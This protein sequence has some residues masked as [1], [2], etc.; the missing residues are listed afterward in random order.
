MKNKINPLIVYYNK[1]I[2]RSLNLEEPSADW[3]WDQLDNTVVQLLSSGK[4]VYFPMTPMS[5]E[6]LTVNR[7]G[8][9]IVDAGATVFSGY[10]DSEEAVQAAEWLRTYQTPWDDYGSKDGYYPMLKIMKNRGSKRLL[11][12]YKLRENYYSKQWMIFKKKLLK[13]WQLLM[14]PLFEHDLISTINRTKAANFMINLHHRI[15][16]PAAYKYLMLKSVFLY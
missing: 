4:K 6:W 14:S 8:G 13:Q 10:L 3:S 1:A 2:F 12:W 15:V 16:T 5:L 7:Y 11:Q 9:R